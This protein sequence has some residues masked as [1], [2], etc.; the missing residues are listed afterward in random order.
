M[1]MF[2]FMGK[3][4]AMSL[5]AKLSLPFELPSIV[6]K[7]LVGEE[8][9]LEDLMA[10]DAIT[11]HLLTAVQK[12]EEDGIVNEEIFAEKYGDKLRWSYNGSD[13]IERELRKGSGSRIVSFDSRLEWCDAVKAVRLGEFN[14][15]IKAIARGMDSVVS[16]RVLQLFSWQ[17]LEILVSGDPR[18]DIESWKSFTDSSG[19]PAK[20]ASLFWTVMASLLPKEQSGFIRF[21][22][23]RSR[24]PPPKDFHVK[25]KLT[26]MTSAAHRLPIAHTC[27]FHVELPDYLTEDE[28][29][30]GLL[31]CIH[32]GGGVLLG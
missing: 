3:L 23:G 22:W 15:Q 20:T 1:E 29:L 6:W 31:T 14:A 17:Q 12:C 19:V 16:M 28:M 10:V 26:R 24:L 30:H 2:E 7:Q 8:V 5:R 13:G 4:M 18:I 27:F 9:D 25:M 21:A 32:F 11:C